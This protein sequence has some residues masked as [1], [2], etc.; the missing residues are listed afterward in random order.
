MPESK[1]IMPESVFG[2]LSKFVYYNGLVGEDEPFV[3]FS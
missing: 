1:T 2:N 3:S